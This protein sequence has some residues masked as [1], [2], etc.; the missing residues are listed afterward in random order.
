M[1]FS[2]F[3][4]VS[5]IKRASKKEPLPQPFEGQTFVIAG[6]II[7][8]KEKPRIDQEKLKKKL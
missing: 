1:R 2:L 4:D 8:R 3:P 7:E 6:N 5:T